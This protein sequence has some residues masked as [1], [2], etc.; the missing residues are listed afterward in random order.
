VA[1]KEAELEVAREK[2]RLEF[3]DD[4]KHEKYMRDLFYNRDR[5]ELKGI[6]PAKDRIRQYKTK[7]IKTGLDSAKPP[8]AAP[9]LRGRSMMTGA[10]SAA[11]F[12]VMPSSVKEGAVRPT[13]AGIASTF[14]QSDAPT[15]A[16]INQ[17]Q[18]ALGLLAQNNR[19]ISMS[20]FSKFEENEK[21]VKNHPFKVF[22]TSNEPTAFHKENRFEGRSNYQY[23]YPTGETHEQELEQYWF[24]EK[25]KDLADKRRDEEAKQTMKTW[26]QARGRME[27][28]ISRKK[29]N[30]NAATNFEKARGWTRSNWKSKHHDPHAELYDKFIEF[31]SS[32]DEKNSAHMSS[33][34]RTLES[35]VKVVRGATTLAVSKSTKGPMFT[36]L[37]KDE[38]GYR[39]RPTTAVLAK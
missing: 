19:A 38:E 2:Q 16:S 36:D 26:G 39:F 11:N 37:T 4:D 9:G 23:Y 29:E 20:R 33:P 17:T 30:I 32:D 12:K 27:A 24:D 10:K 35:P 13:T 22:F 31:S 8:T 7:I 6:P 34:E 1:A 18:S 15:A 25:N 28:E 3:M 21:S 14:G 5:T